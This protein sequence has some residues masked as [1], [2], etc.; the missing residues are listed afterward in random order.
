M[1]A[2]SVGYTIIYMIHGDSDY[3]YHDGDGNPVRADERIAAEARRVAERA[4]GGEVFIF[5]QLPERRIFGLIPDDSRKMI[6]YRGGE[7]VSVLDYSSAR[8]NRLF[9]AEYSLFSRYRAGR[10]G[11]D[12]KG[13]DTEG[14]DIKTI[15]LYFG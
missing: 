6:Y 14:D 9:H 4:V 1:P 11:D 7:K 12:M 2:D 13:D 10:S 8:D 15:F 5:H 3:L